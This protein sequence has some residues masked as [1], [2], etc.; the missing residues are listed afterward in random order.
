M[1]SLRVV[2]RFGGGVQGQVLE[3]RDPRRAPP[4]GGRPLDAEHVVG[5]G[6]AEG[7]VLHV[8][9]GLEPVRP[10]SPHLEARAVE[11]QRQVG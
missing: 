5:E 6:A 2:Q 1:P 4:A 9:F 8:G 11:E 10:H 7:Q 3:A